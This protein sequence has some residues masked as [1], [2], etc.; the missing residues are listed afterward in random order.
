MLL[1]CN[2]ILTAWSK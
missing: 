1:I 2:L